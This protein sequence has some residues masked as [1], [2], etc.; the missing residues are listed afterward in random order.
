M[1]GTVGVGF[2]LGSY[3]LLQIGVIRGSGLTYALMNLAAASFVLISLMSEF[4]LFS[5]IIQVSWIVISVFGLTRLFIRTRAV[6][7]SPEEEAFRADKLQHMSSL[8]AR[9]LLNAGQWLEAPEETVLIDDG[10]PADALFYLTR[11]SA[12]VESDGKTIAHVTP[13]SFLGEITVLSDD[14]ATARVIAGPDA[15]LFRLGRSALR[16]LVER[17]PE[18]RDQVHVA[19]T[20]D[21]RNKTL[22]VNQAI[23]GELERA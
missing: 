11:G 15:R 18:F 22:A 5:A 1:S 19:L 4:N 13:G 2:Y 21:T 6:R 3:F 23:K 14:P 8:N 12:R 20:T 16:A 17:D 7:F 9:T 10:A